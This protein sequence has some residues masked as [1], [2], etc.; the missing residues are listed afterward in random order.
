MK[1]DFKP[2]LLGSPSPS[3]RRNYRDSY[4]S[5]RGD[6]RYSKRRYSR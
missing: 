5:R 1:H 6:D 3:R 2:F 4:N